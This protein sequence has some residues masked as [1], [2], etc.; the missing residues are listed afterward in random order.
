MESVWRQSLQ[1]TLAS[2]VKVQWLKSAICA[3]IVGLGMASWASSAFAQAAWSTPQWSTATTDGSTTDFDTGTLSFPAQTASQIRVMAPGNG[4]FHNHG[5]PVSATIEVL[6]NGVWTLVFTSVPDTTGSGIFISSFPTPVAT[7]TPGQVAGVRMSCTQYVGYCYHGVENT[8]YFE[9]SGGGRN[10]SEVI[11]SFMSRR[12]D[13]LLSNGPDRGREID[14]LVNAQGDGPTGGAPFGSPSGLGAGSNRLGGPDGLTT[15]AQPSMSSLAARGAPGMGRLER[16]FDPTARGVEESQ[17]GVEAG[18]PRSGGDGSPNRVS[19]SSSLSKMMQLGAAEG[20][21]KAQEMSML[22]VRETPAAR[23]SASAWDIWFAGHYQNFDDDRRNVNGEGHFGV[24]YLGADVVLSPRLLV[25]MLVQF[26]DMQLKSQS[27]A[28]SVKGHGW[29]V[30]PYATLRLAQ[31]VFL[32]GRAAWGKSNNEVSPSL[33]FIDE[34]DTT[35]WLT[36]A[37]IV[38]RYDFGALQVRPSATIAYIEDKSEAYTSVST[39]AV[40]A[41]DTSLGQFKAGPMFSYVMSGGGGVRYEPRL[42][43]EGIWNFDSSTNVVDMGGTLS[44]PEG[45]RGRIEVGLKTSLSTGAILDLSGSYDGIGAG[46]FSSWGGRAML[47]LPLN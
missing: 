33:T 18:L 13:L 4:I 12:N 10:A 14:R 1:S 25:G 38:G 7:F 31:N 6:L 42:G 45:V 8:M 17:L 23:P 43:L 39:A 16:G 28:Y 24:F 27:S 35:R 15:N 32:Q 44:G 47:R 9:L 20:D 46:D 37:T 19:F 2:G 21:R 30:G 40:P 29:M 22:G 26:D 41:V 11:A 36:T 3:A 34:F 5:D